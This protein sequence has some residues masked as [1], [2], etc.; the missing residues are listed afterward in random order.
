[1]IRQK[2]RTGKSRL[3]GHLAVIH[4]VQVSGLA[5]KALI[6][7]HMRSILS[8]FRHETYSSLCKTA[9]A[10]LLLKRGSRCQPRTNPTADN[11]RKGLKQY[12]GRE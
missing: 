3:S 2:V 7:H 11:L 1:M 9:P 10:G 6:G 5:E 8:D 12:F 4:N